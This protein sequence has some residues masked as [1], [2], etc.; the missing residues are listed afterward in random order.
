M[1]LDHARSIR[2]AHTYCSW[3]LHIADQTVMQIY[4]GGRTTPACGQ[5]ARYDW[6]DDAWTDMSL[7]VPRNHPVAMLLVVWR[8]HRGCLVSEQYLSAPTPRFADHAATA[9]TSMAVDLVHRVLLRINSTHRCT[10]HCV[11]VS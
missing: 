8:A 2:T 6:Q 7:T 11:S 10:I 9:Q 5:T 3:S 4:F 1:Y